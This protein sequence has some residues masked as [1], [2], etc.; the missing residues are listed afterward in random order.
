MKAK[1]IRMNQ[2]TEALDNIQLI[3]FNS[4]IGRFVNLVNDARKVEIKWMMKGFL[5]AVINTGML[6]F[7]YPMLSLAIFMTTFLVFELNITLA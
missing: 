1:D 2:T 4:W 5:I 7:L 6:K 3:K